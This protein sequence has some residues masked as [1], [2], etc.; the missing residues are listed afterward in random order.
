MV[1][2]VQFVALLCAA[3]VGQVQAS[4]VREQQKMFPSGPYYL[5]GLPP[6]PRPSA[7]ADFLLNNSVFQY[8]L[9]LGVPG[10]AAAGPGIQGPFSGPNKTWQYTA[11]ALSPAET[12]AWQDSSEDFTG[13]RRQ[14]SI[15]NPG[16]IERNKAAR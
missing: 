1:A 6:T 10:I 5:N 8:R 7:P 12:L 11:A 9:P 16:G 15:E 14:E 13:H 3:N 4:S 2:L